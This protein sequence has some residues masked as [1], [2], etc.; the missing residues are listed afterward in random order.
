VKFNAIERAHYARL[1]DGRAV[2]QYTLASAS[3]LRVKIITYGGTITA[4]DAPDRAGR[5]ANVVLGY[6]DIGGYLSEKSTYFGALIGRF[7][8][9]IAGGRFTLRGRDYSL[10]VN[11]GPNSLHGGRRGFDKAVWAAHASGEPDGHA[12]LSLTHVSPDGDEGYPGTLA[13]RV[14]YV[15]EE[16]ALRIA[17]RAETD[18][19]TVLNLTNHTYFNLAGEAS[20]DALAQE[21]T[22]DADAYTPVDATMIP[23]GEIAP[24]A[25]TAFDFRKPR[26]LGLHV[27]DDDP[28]LLLAQGYDHNWVLNRNAGDPPSLAV[29][30]YDPASGRSVDVLTTEPGVQVYSGNFL[31]GTQTGSGGKIY[32]QGAGWT[33]ET[34][35]F[36]NSPNIS[37]FPT[38]EL[39]AGQIF[40]SET[41]F[42]FSARARA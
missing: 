26:P 31:A 42:R 33:A 30:G 8:N 2:E 19:D 39:R 34:Q 15:L 6:P 16:D 14:T 29:R 9:R 12:T 37:R 23:T 18:R 36:P 5:A 41:V 24:V 40:N 20:G 27:R 10:A 32:R 38:T 21:L 28:Q 1:S 4:I 35:H 3:G 11:D 17:Y 13:V 25:G 22:I 7:A